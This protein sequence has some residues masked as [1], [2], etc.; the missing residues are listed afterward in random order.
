MTLGDWLNERGLRRPPPRKESIRDPVTS[1]QTGH[2]ERAVGNWAS[3]VLL[4]VGWF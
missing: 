4:L 2:A 3:L 1:W